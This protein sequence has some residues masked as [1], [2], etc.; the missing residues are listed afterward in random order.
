MPSS[1]AS[2]VNSSATRRR[3]SSSLRLIGQQIIEPN[4]PVLTD[5]AER[6]FPVFQQTDQVWPGDIEE[7]C[8]LLRR[9]LRLDRK[10]GY[11][12][13]LSHF[14]QDILEQSKGGRRQD[15]LRADCSSF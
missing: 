3:S 5:Q 1:W 10:K 13:A 8:R 6:D 9:Q 15:D 12:V 14:R 11:P 4:T 2:A 7:V